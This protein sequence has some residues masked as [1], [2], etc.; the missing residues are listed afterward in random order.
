MSETKQYTAEQDAIDAKC[1][2]FWVYEAFNNPLAICRLLSRCETE[3]DYRDAI[4][5][6]IEAA[7]Q[8]TAKATGEIK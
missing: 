6:I 1:F 2:R 4:M 8:V 3:Q 5:P 7:E